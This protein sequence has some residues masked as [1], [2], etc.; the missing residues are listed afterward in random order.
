MKI[1]AWTSLLTLGAGL[2]GV[3]VGRWTDAGI[4]ILQGTA[5]IWHHLTYTPTSLAVDRAAL[6]IVIVRTVQNAVTSG[7]FCI[8]LYSSVYAYVAFLYLYGMQTKRYCFDPNPLVGD[9]YHASMHIIVFAVYSGTM[10]WL[11]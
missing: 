9:L 5:S 11:L 6:S 2:V 8:G 1:L 10:L 7:A 4:L 3:G